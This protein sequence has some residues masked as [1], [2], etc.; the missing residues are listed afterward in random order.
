MEDVG[1][2]SDACSWSKL[3]S[4]H[5]VVQGVTKDRCAKVLT[6]N[7]GPRYRGQ[8]ESVN[9]QIDTPETLVARNIRDKIS[10]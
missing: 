8:T 5:F 7:E 2:G 3:L 9:G 10:R 6:K 4:Q 1:T